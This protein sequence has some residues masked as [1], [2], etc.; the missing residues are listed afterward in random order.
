MQEMDFKNWQHVF[1]LDPDKEISDETLEA[2]CESGTDAIIVGGTLNVTFDNTIDLLS[3]VRRYAL[4]CVLE[5]SNI[6]AIVPGYDAYFVPLVLNAQKP[7]WILDAH[8]RGLEEYGPFIKWDEV[9]VEGYVVGNGESA[10]A[11]LTGSRTDIT[12]ERIKA[13]ARLADQMLKFPIF[14]IEYSGAY[15]DPKLVRAAHNVIHNSRIFYGGGIRSAEQA[16]EMAR[17]ADTVVVGNL[18]YEDN[19]QALATVAAVKKQK[20]GEM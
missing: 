7:E 12:E 19:E 11:R 9:F 2:V 3:R 15:G 10:V 14:Y 1:K 5:V 16:A 20:E 4:P 6:D 17:W 18:V 8:V 13:Y